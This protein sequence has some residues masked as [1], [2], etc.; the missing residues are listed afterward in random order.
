[1]H[2]A[3]KFIVVIAVIGAGVCA[4][5]PFRRM[6]PPPESTL[7]Q[8]DAPDNDPDKD[9]DTFGTSAVQQPRRPATDRVEL[10]IQGTP[11]QFDAFGMADVEQPDAGTDQ[12][13]RTTHAPQIRARQKQESEFAEF[14]DPAPP[15]DLPSAFQR[16]IRSD[17]QQADRPS[18]PDTADVDRKKEVERA[19]Q[20]NNKRNSQP[21]R[22]G[23]GRDRAENQAEETPTSLSENPDPPASPDRDETRERNSPSELA[24]FGGTGGSVGKPAKTDLGS[25]EQRDNTDRKTEKTGRRAA[26]GERSADDLTGDE[27][28]RGQ[29]AEQ[30]PWSAN[31]DMADT[32]GN[33]AKEADVAAREPAATRLPKDEPHHRQDTGF[34]AWEDDPLDGSAHRAFGQSASPND[35]SIAIT[36]PAKTPHAPPRNTAPDA[37]P[38]QPAR[39]EHAPAAAPNA[40]RRPPPAS[41]AATRPSPDG[42][43][44]T[45]TEPTPRIAKIERSVDSASGDCQPHPAAPGE[46]RSWANDQ[47]PV[48]PQVA[49]RAP[50]AVDGSSY[51][52]QYIRHR[53]AD[54][55]SLASLAQRYLGDRNRYAEIFHANRHLLASPDILPIGV[56]LTIPPATTGAAVPPAS[57]VQPYSTGGWQ[58][59]D[60]ARVEQELVPIPPD[61]FPHLNR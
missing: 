25:V 23:A 46:I 14:A 53:V 17:E 6:P 37:A 60:E 11:E 12:N 1:M 21:N 15:P 54:G 61:A 7:A 49:S 57:T 45:A 40:G 52:S 27:T 44:D 51:V 3:T 59:R 9:P 30:Q 18:P 10:N 56:I 34:Q 24:T 32:L 26:I 8:E 38:E 28:I 42:S 58:P 22:R 4:A 13:P 31:T 41:I 5:L 50:T 20:G 39:N 43:P 33:F 2:N 29:P 48:T 16:S 47:P 36:Q 35:D 55:D 19:S